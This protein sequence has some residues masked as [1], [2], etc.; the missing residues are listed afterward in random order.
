MEAEQQHGAT[1]R[2]KALVRFHR[3]GVV[4]VRSKTP[5][6]GYRTRTLL[7]CGGLSVPHPSL[8]LVYNQ[9]S[10]GSQLA[11]ACEASSEMHVSSFTPPPTLQGSKSTPGS[12][13]SHPQQYYLHIYR[14]RSPKQTSGTTRPNH[15]T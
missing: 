12:R 1:R 10:G 4:C 3:T 15:Q 7:D 11:P 5:P 8:F 2:E 9:A 14:V 13:V 6:F